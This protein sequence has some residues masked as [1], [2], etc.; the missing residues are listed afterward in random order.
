MIILMLSSLLNIAYLLPIPLRAF[1]IKDEGKQ[2]E[3]RIKEAPLLSLLALS[4]TAVGCL[5]L[6]FYTQP[7]FELASAFLEAG[8]VPYGG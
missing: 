5:V 7:L 8:G 2:S 3:I 4:V 1:F 6:F